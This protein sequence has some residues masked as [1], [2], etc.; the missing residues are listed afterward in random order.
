MILSSSTREGGSGGTSDKWLDGILSFTAFEW[1][2][3]SDCVCR[4]AV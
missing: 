2:K 3:C 1:K 4:S